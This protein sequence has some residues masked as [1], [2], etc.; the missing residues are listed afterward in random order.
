VVDYA[1]QHDAQLIVLGVRQTSMLASHLPAQIAYRMIT[2]A[3]CPVLTIAVEHNN[4]AKL[5]EACL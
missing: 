3:P 1:K 5:S 4:S 2:E